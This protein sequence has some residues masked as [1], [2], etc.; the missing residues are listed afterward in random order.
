MIAVS[1]D[2]M[3]EGIGEAVCGVAG[4]DGGTMIGTWMMIGAGA[5]G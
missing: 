3:F 2:E 5:G 4:V 1:L